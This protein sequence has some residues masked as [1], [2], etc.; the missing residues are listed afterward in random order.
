MEAQRREERL[1]WEEEDAQKGAEE[2]F[3]IYKKEGAA[4]QTHTPPPQACYYFSKL[5]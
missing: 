3:T 2:L 4:W 1:E 5:E